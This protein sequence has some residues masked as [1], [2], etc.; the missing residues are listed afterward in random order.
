ML[1]LGVVPPRLV[2][3]AVNGRVRVSDLMGFIWDV[4]GFNGIYMDLMGF[5]LIFTGIYF[6][7]VGLW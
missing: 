5:K 2:R 4:Y 7:M 6:Q 3:G 1:R